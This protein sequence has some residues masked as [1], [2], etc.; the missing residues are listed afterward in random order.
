MKGPEDLSLRPA[1]L[2]AGTVEK[3]VSA[4]FHRLFMH[5]H[6]NRNLFTQRGLQA[7]SPEQI[8][9][10]FVDTFLQQHEGT[11]NRAQRHPIWL[12]KDSQTTMWHKN[13]KPSSILLC[14]SVLGE[15]NISS[16]YHIHA[17]KQ[18]NK[19][20]A[21]SHGDDFLYLNTKK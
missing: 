15:L 11:N 19:I 10:K 1:L 12:L 7:S 2:E 14:Q 16:R 13:F 18:R 9:S 5:H 20:L 6:S 4:D 17:V 8:G 3:S 21:I